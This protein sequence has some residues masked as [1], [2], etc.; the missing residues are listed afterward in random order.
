MATE[1]T[2]KRWGNSM[3]IIIPK[4]IIKEKKIREKEK[5]IVEIMKKAD[6]SDIFGTLP[7]RMS[8]QK[9]KDEARK[10]WE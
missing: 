4:E 2:V 1:V 7:R 3:G 10:G 8:A 5:I 9:L 6:L